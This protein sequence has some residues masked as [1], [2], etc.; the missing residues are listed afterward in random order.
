MAAALFVPEFFSN[1]TTFIG[2]EPGPDGKIHNVS[3]T[4]CTKCGYVLSQT[5]YGCCGHASCGFGTIHHDC[6]E[7]T[8]TTDPS[9]S[10]S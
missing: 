10:K 2:Q 4:T 3:R 5:H 9:S 7:A 6:T 8:C 1:Q